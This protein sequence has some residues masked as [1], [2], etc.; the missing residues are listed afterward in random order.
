MTQPISTQ[1]LT[2]LLSITTSLL[3]SGAILSFSY[4]TVPILLSAPPPLSLPHLRALFS[5][6]S[7]IFPQLATLSS[8]GFAYL[9]YHAPAGT[10]ARLQYAV[11]AAGVIGIAPWTV[12]V[13]KG[14][15]MTLV[16]IEKEGEEGVRKAGGEERVKGLMKRF[17]WMNAVR[18]GI[19][20]VGAG[21]GA[22]A[23]IGGR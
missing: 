4:S 7:H 15:N 2:A 23:A 21:V 20:A 1:Q 8:A 13:M 16:A 19:M 6:G 18:G 10:N 22:W 9:A 17:R 3:T 11:A 12:F 14:T 5:S